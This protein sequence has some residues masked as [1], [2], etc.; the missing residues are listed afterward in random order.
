MIL[1]VCGGVLEATTLAA[2]DA[3]DA[4]VREAA[5]LLDVEQVGA[6]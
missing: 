3:V 5:A 6:R 1:C 4:L 2:L